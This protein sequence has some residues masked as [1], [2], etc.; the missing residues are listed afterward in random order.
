M[1]G[2]NLGRRDGG[3][4]DALSRNLPVGTEEIHVNVASVLIEIRSDHLERKK[5]LLRQ[6][7]RCKR[8]LLNTFHILSKDILR[9]YI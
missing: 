9:F 4:I 6:P 3:L 7:D 1:D 2:R 8:I 5:S